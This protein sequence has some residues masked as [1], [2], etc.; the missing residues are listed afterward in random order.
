M[1]GGDEM[2]DEK[3]QTLMSF[4]G[5]TLIADRVGVDEVNLPMI[6]HWVEAMQMTEGIHLSDEVARTHGR[7]QLVA[8]AAMTQA[9]VMRGYA[10]TIDPTRIAPDGYSAL[11]AALDD[12]GYTSVVATNSDLTFE[13]ELVIGDVI[14]YSEVVDSIS[15][16]KTT[17]LGVGRFVTTTK[18]YRDQTGAIVARQVWRTLRFRPQ[19]LSAAA[20][21]EA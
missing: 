5:A 2:T 8:P 4:V 15:D 20:T 17:G 7:A 3:A 13:R 6:R 18:T 14:S 12:A 11:I 1:D 19:D 16:E 9:W 10:A 21:K